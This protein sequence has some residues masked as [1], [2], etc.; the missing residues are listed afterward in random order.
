[1]RYLLWLLAGA[2][3]LEF[4]L[5]AFENRHNN[6]QIHNSYYNVPNF[7][8]DEISQR[9]R[10]EYNLYDRLQNQQREAYRDQYQSTPER[11]GYYYYQFRD[12]DSP[13]QFRRTTPQQQYNNP[14]QY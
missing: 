3:A 13:P 1:M 12:E 11:Q 7:E 8:D 2:L 14:Y 4:S 6:Q 5:N 10:D 9:N